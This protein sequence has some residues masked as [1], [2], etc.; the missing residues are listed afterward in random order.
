MCTR[1]W[2]RPV[3]RWYVLEAF[4]YALVAA[5]M[6]QHIR[7]P[8]VVQD[9]VEE[10]Q[11]WYSLA[12]MVRNQYDDEGRLLPPISAGELNSLFLL[13]AL[14]ASPQHQDA[15]FE[16]VVSELMRVTEWAQWARQTEPQVKEGRCLLLDTAAERPS[17]MVWSRTLYL[18]RN[19]V[20]LLQGGGDLFHLLC[21]QAYD[22][23]HVCAPPAFLGAPHPPPSGRPIHVGFTAV[24]WTANTL[25]RLMAGVVVK[26]AAQ[27]SRF[28]VTLIGQPPKGGPDALWHAL[29]HIVHG[30]V[31]LPE[32][33]SAS[34]QAVLDR[35]LDVRP[36]RY[37]WRGRLFLV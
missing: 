4:S 1:C 20:S 8:V 17:V 22:A 2:G 18:G 37:P 26:L 15:A 5:N 36:S 27:A 33:I 32:S 24:T 25:S 31:E 14:P 7:N 6:A 34:R 30:I 23:Q 29:H 21:P 9:D 11:R 28:R 16:R 35:N 12:A 13:P 10:A 3:P 19:V